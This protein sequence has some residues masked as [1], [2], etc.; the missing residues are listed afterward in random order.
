LRQLRQEGAGKK[1]NGSKKRAEAAR[2][3]TQAVASGCCVPGLVVEATGQPSA[4][5]GSAFACIG[6]VG[7]TKLMFDPAGGFSDR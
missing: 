4:G 1:G 5:E 6:L 3:D 7:E 2:L